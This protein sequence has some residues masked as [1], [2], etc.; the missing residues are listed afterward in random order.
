MKYL[1]IVE[2]DNDYAFFTDKEVEQA[3]WFANHLRREGLKVRMHA[4]THDGEVDEAEWND[5]YTSS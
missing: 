2:S 1:Y 5:E 3:K 4:F